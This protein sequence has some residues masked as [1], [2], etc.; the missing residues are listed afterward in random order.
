MTH[1]LVIGGVSLDLLHVKNKKVLSAG[2][3]GVY[4][5]MAAVHCGVKASLFAPRPDPVPEELIEVDR[6][7]SSWLGPVVPPSRLPHFEIEHKGDN[8][9]YLS[10]V[11]GAEG[12]L[13]VDQLPVDLSVY[14]CVHVTPL[15]DSALQQEFI[16][17]CRQRGARMISAGTYLCTAKQ[18]GSVVRQSIEAADVFFMNE[19]EACV[20]FGSLDQAV[21]Q[22]DKLLFITRGSQGCMVVQGNQQRQLNAVAAKVVDPTGAGDTFCGA[23]LA[24]LIRGEQPLLA[25]QQASKL[26]ALEIEA[27]GPAAFLQDEFSG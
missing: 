23:V 18:N 11:I 19:E 25:A 10:M 7:L 27:V 24:G 26:A 20:L 1:L 21:P 9:H 15:G 2:G 16:K 6:R 5:S 17:A 3:A 13:S 12:E 14:N 8:A 22:P 4:T